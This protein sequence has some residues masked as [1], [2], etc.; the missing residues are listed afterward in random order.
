MPTKGFLAASANADTA[1]SSVNSVATMN[2]PD[3]MRR[4]SYS[5]PSLQSSSR[6][7]WRPPGAARLAVGSILPLS[8]RT[9]GIRARMPCNLGSIRVPVVWLNEPETR[10]KQTFRESVI[11]DVGNWCNLIQIR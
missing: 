4:A 6:R 9:R 1:V 8:G 7:S 11:E 2:D 5:P 3:F 10:K